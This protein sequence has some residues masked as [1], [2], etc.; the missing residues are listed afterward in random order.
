[1][2]GGKW[3]YILIYAGLIAEKGFKIEKKFRKFQFLC[4]KAVGFGDNSGMERSGS[5]LLN[6]P[7]FTGGICLSATRTAPLIGVIKSRPLFTRRFIMERSETKQPEQGHVSAP[8]ASPKDKE[9]EVTTGSPRLDGLLNS[10]LN[11]S[12]AMT[13]VCLELSKAN[14]QLGEGIAAML[15]TK[16]EPF[17]RGEFPAGLDLEAEIAPINEWLAFLDGHISAA[18]QEEPKELDRDKIVRETVDILRGKKAAA[19]TGISETQNIREKRFQEGLNMVRERL[20]GFDVLSREEILGT[21]LEDIH[22]VTDKASRLNN[23]RDRVCDIYDRLDA[24]AKCAI[25]VL[26]ELAAVDG[27]SVGVDYGYEL[28]YQTGR[29][30]GCVEQALTEL[31]DDADVKCLAEVYELSSFINQAV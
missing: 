14:S 9:Q 11:E 3:L 19:E 12:L 25:A 15:K 18:E 28:L 13:Y 10:A 16:I 17:R 5:S 27:C 1:M 8:G 26:Q 22:K 29:D 2:L 23:L 24:K 21:A 6:N 4:C 20:R 7:T 30:V 31:P